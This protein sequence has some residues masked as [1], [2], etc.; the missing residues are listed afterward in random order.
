M[1][2]RGTREGCVNE[3]RSRRDNWHPRVKKEPGERGTSE[4]LVLS[5]LSPGAAKRYRTGAA[6]HP[7]EGARNQSFGVDPSLGGI[8]IEHLD[9]PA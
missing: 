6:F 4:T 9:R 5:R 2:R 8:G 3:F 1:R 7:L